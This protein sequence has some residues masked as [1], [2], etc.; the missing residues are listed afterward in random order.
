MTNE[1]GAYKLSKKELKDINC[2]LLKDNIKLITFSFRYNFFVKLF[3]LAWSFFFLVCLIRYSNIRTIHAFCTPAGA[4]AYLLSLITGKRLVIDSYE[5]HAESMVENGTWSENSLKFKI[6]FYLEKK[7]SE[8]ADSVI[9]ATYGMRDYALD[10]YGVVFSKYYVKPACVDLSLF[11]YE[12]KKDPS[13]VEEL[14]L[15]GKRVIVYAGKFGGIYLEKDAFDFFR[16]AQ[17]FY[18]D[19]L[20][21]VLLTGHKI[22]EVSKLCKGSEVDEKGLIVR[23]VPHHDVPRY[24]GLADIAFTP[25]KPVPTKRYCTPIK[26]GEYWAL[27]LPIIITENISDDSDIIFKGGVGALIIPGDANS[28]RKALNHVEGIINLTSPEELYMKIRN[29]AEKYRSFSIAENIYKEVYN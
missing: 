3:S 17:L 2:E 1:Q 26:D 29:L 12:Q 4:L 21:I 10:K 19:I 23:F 11:S 6:L 22:E 5:P 20:K 27:G 15:R 24:M 8:R 28:Y 25:V 9:A 14:G 13:L 16:E 18:G 7:M